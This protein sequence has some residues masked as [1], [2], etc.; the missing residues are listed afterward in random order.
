MAEDG[1]FNML[2][3]WLGWA[4]YAWTNHR[5][6]HWFA[7]LLTSTILRTSSDSWHAKANQVYGS[8]KKNTIVQ[9]KPT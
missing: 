8:I 9:N 1:M 3:N 5:L 2:V 4:S 6:G 7:Q